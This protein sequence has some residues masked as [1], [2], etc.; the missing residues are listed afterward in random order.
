MPKWRVALAAF[1]ACVVARPSLAANPQSLAQLV[2]QGFEIKTV[3]LVPPDAWDVA[4]VTLQKVNTIAVCTYLFSNWSS[5]EESLVT[6]TNQCTIR[7][8]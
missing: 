7:S 1:A 3:N 8:F 6:G 4:A 2:A 5:L